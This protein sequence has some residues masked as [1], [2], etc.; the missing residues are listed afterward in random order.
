M[1]EMSLCSSPVI[2]ILT[3]GITY[4]CRLGARLGFYSSL[5]I[6][7]KTILYSWA[8]LAGMA[9]IYCLPGDMLWVV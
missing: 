7:S 1:V 2:S 8:C 5:F 6:A 3:E 4:N 9:N